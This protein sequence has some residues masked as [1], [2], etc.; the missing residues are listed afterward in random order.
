MTGT[1]AFILIGFLCLLNLFTQAVESTPFSVVGIYPHLTVSSESAECAIGG[2]SVSGDSLR[3]MTTSSN[4][5]GQLYVVSPDLNSTMV[6]E[7][8]G[9]PG[10]EATW[11]IGQDD[12]SF[13]LKTKQA[14]S[15]QTYRLPKASYAVDARSID[16]FCIQ[17]MKDG[18]RLMMTPGIFWSFPTTF[19]PQN[20]AGIRPIS[21]F[22]KQVNDVA[23]WRDQLVFGCNDATRLD[24]RLC[25]RAQ[26]NMVFLNPNS[27]SSFGPRSAFGGIWLGSS[28]KKKV[29]SDPFLFGGFDRRILHLFHA[30]SSGIRF[31]VEVD[32]KGDG[33]W[34]FYKTIAVG[35]GRYIYHIFPK[36]MNA[37]WIRITSGVTCENV[38]AY[39]HYTS[40]EHQT[41]SASFAAL[42]AYHSHS[43]SEGLLFPS[44]ERQYALQFA[45]WKVDKKGVQT[46][47]GY[48][49]LSEDMTLSAVDNPTAMSWMKEHIAEK[50]PAFTVD[51]ASVLVI[52]TH[53]GIE[54]RWRLPKGTKQT[55]ETSSMGWPRASREVVAHRLLFNCQGTFYEQP[56]NEGRGIVGIKPICTHNRK[57]SDFCSWRGMLVMAGHLDQSKPAEHIINSTDGQTGLWVGSVDNLWALGKPTGSGGPWMNTSVKGGQ[58]SDPYLM[59]GYDHKT[60][61]IQHY[62]GGKGRR[63][64]VTFKVEV[65]VTN[66]GIWNEYKLF[67]LR[68]GEKLSYTFDPEFSAHWIRITT[69]ADCSATVQFEYK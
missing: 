12:A 34:T 4:D 57:I 19:S 43:F 21:T 44:G 36:K 26:S 33:N 14:A 69:S 11:S 15:G 31:D 62:G 17:E 5:K 50:E 61:H 3:V 68:D 51:D 13:I 10:I 41:D 23:F 67:T 56:R 28:V 25:G 53:E 60:M 37:E 65:D 45:A 55:Y 32:E 47:L 39:F 7:Q 24:P 30:H 59:T 46:E 63:R 27:L 52:E 18:N 42:P 9:D 54:K 2:L 1:R 29:P 35:P 38:T 64:T 6:S 16:G 49:E 58:P 22:L 40:A 20:S 8:E 48:Y 66:Q